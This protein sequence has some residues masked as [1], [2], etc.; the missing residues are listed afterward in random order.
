MLVHFGNKLQVVLS[1]VLAQMIINEK[2]IV[3]FILRTL[4]K[5][6]ALRARGFR[7]NIWSSKSTSIFALMSFCHIHE[8]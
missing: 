4:P 8:A 1:C 6:I 5:L 2:R 3:S 7:N